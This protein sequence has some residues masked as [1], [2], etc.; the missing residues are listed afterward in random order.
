MLLNH[1]ISKQTREET[2]VGFLV[3][4]SFWFFLN[5]VVA[6]GKYNLSLILATSVVIPTVILVACALL[7]PWLMGLYNRLTSN[8]AHRRLIASLASTKSSSLHLSSDEKNQLSTVMKSTLFFKAVYQALENGFRSITIAKKPEEKLAYLPSDN[9]NATRV[10]ISD[11]PRKVFI[12]FYDESERDRQHTKGRQHL[13]FDNSYNNMFWN[14]HIK[15]GNKVADGGKRQIRLKDNS[16]KPRP[17]CYHPLKTSTGGETKCHPT[18]AIKSQML[19]QCVV[20]SV[21]LRKYKHGIPGYNIDFS[22]YSGPTIGAQLSRK[23][24]MQSV[25]NVDKTIHKLPMITRALI[26][27]MLDQVSDQ[28]SKWHNDTSMCHGDVKMENI[29]WIT[30]KSGNTSNKFTLIDYPDHEDEASLAYTQH[31][32]VLTDTHDFITKVIMDLPFK[33]SSG[34]NLSTPNA[35]SGKA[36]IPAADRE[37]LEKALAEFEKR[38]VRAQAGSVRTVNNQSQPSR[39]FILIHKNTFYHDTFALTYLALV[40]VCMIDEND[41]TKNNQ[42]E[43]RI[44]KLLETMIH[45]YITAFN[46]VGPGANMDIERRENRAMKNKIIDKM[47]EKC[48]LTETIKNLKEILGSSPAKSKG[49]S[50]GRIGPLQANRIF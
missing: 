30:Q 50:K 22:D 46:S 27:Q 12:E 42:E 20:P 10:H 25:V 16:A 18:I 40:M 11:M 19:G 39:Q 1:F 28:L 43:Q 41:K 33:L 9:D 47:N 49:N 3:L 21:T 31:A 15:P 38:S 37:S 35:L 17:D 24:Y 7:I 36:T 29:C 45:E 48:N 8:L 34:I 32:S 5:A 2:Y 23:A 4:A 44:F 6:I 13:G 14:L 26:V